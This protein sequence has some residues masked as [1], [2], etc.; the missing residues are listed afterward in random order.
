MSKG[1]IYLFDI[2]VC[3]GFVLLIVA[4]LTVLYYFAY[5]FFPP[6]WHLHFFLLSDSEELNIYECFLIPVQRVGKH[7]ARIIWQQSWLRRLCSPISRPC[8][9]AI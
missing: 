9:Y 1:K 2:K 4:L 5:L 3:P 7:V 8:C 6:L